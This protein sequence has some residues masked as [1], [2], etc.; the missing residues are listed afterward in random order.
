MLLLKGIHYKLINIVICR[1]NYRNVTNFKHLN[2]LINFYFYLLYK[3]YQFES[4]RYGG[5]QA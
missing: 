3:H 2:K 5:F 4:K 1:I